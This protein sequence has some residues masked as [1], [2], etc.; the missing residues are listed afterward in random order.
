MRKEILKL[1]KEIKKIKKRQENLE[2]DLR[3]FIRRRIDH[4]M[5]KEIYMIAQ[6]A[7]SLT[8]KVLEIEREVKKI[9]KNFY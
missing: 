9:K 4:A 7:S 3:N 8:R 6:W 5:K 2:K 1:E